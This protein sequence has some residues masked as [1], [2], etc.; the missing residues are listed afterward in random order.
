VKVAPTFDFVLQPPVQNDERRTTA[1]GMTRF[2]EARKAR[3]KKSA[4]KCGQQFR[5]KYIG[6]KWAPKTPEAGYLGGPKLWGSWWYA[7]LAKGG[8]DEVTLEFVGNRNDSVKA[9]EQYVIEASTGR[10]AGYSLTVPDAMG[11]GTVYFYK[12][13]NQSK[14][15]PWQHNERSTGDLIYPGDE[16]F[17][18]SERYLPHRLTMPYDPYQRLSLDAPDPDDPNGIRYVRWRA[19][20]WDIWKIET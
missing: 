5:L 15:I 20:Q 13:K 3:K 7:V 16:I 2:D 11:A 10:A 8:Y 17:L 18:F 12:G 14:W 4:L 9:G 1:A 19:G 6:D